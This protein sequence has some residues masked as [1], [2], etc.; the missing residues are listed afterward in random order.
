MPLLY[1]T[2]TEIVKK[3]SEA[4]NEASD[5]RFRLFPLFFGVLLWLIYALNSIPNGDLKP[6][7]LP[8]ILFLKNFVAENVAKS[9]VG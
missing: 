9:I 2:G 5:K 8:I 4:C 6:V 3:E 1:H 7:L